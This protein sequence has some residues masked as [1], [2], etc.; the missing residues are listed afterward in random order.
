MDLNR[1]NIIFGRPLLWND[2][3]VKA[4]RLSLCARGR[5]LF[6]TSSIG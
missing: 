3:D 1:T 4:R 6:R 2:F 5:D